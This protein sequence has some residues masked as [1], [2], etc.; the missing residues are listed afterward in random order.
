[1]IRSLFSR[2]CRRLG[3]EDGF[4]L[5][6]ALGATLALAI[7]GTSIAYYSTSNG[8]ATAH[9]RNDQIAFALA[10]AGLQM[11]YSRLAAAPNPGMASAEP[12]TGAPASV[13]M[14]GGTASYFGS[15]DDVNRV[16]TLTGVGTAVVPATGA[17]LVETV[18]GRARV[19]SATRGSRNNAIWNY[20]YADA[21][22]GCTRLDNTVEINVP[23][24]IRGNLCMYNTAT[25]TSYAVQ[26][27]GTVTL[28][29]SSNTVGTAAAPLHEVHV[30]RGCSTDGRSYAPCGPAQRVYA[31]T[32]DATPSALTKPPIDLAGTYEGAQPGPR[33]GC[34]T[35]SFPGGFDNDGVLN[36]SRGNV[37][38]FPSAPYDCRVYSGTT[39][40]G[41]MTWDGVRDF[42]VLG[43]IFI[44]GNIVERNQNHVVYH[45]KA[46]IYASGT[47]SISNQ[48]TVCGTDVNC[49]SNWNVTN[50]LLAFVSGAPCPANGG[51]LDGF[52]IDNFSTLQGAIYTVCDYGEGNHTTVWGPIISRQLYFANSTINH[53]VPIGT[54]LSGMPATYEQ[55]VT[56][57][58]EPGSW[59]T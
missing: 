4:A 12:S 46:T 52:N 27:G 14:E 54:P 19:G 55:V 11:A 35:G 57:S 32:V 49:T 10:E 53:Y 26:V 7:G 38:L 51:R 58:P 17:R 23:L 9:V 15:Y 3:R 39:L 44:D 36:T 6:L 31:E 16:W 45:G 50:D 20:V 1:V 29:S 2:I 8:N 33:H 18:T 43:T 24:Y 25:V 22:T 48:T 42:T 59:G 41:Q 40:V 13:P 47:I 28:N 56:I 21:L 5:V 34:T 37:D 30:A